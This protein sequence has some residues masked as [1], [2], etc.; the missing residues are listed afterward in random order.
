MTPLCGAVI[1][2]SVFVATAAATFWLVEGGEFANAFTD[3][4]NYLASW[5][6]SVFH[7]VVRTFFTFVLPGAFVAYLPTLALLGRSDPTGLP[8]WASWCAPLAAVAA[9]TAAG[10]V[11]RAGVRHY[12]GAGS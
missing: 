3:G 11:W 8:G 4:G 2:G 9:A 5:P 1:F 7:T 10:L 12:V 6:L